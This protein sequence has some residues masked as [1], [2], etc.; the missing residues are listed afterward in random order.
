MN[1]INN[2]S[3]KPSRLHTIIIGAGPAGLAAANSLSALGINNFLLIERGRA[4]ENRQRAREEDIASGVGGAGLY[5]DGKFSF[6]PSATWLWKNLADDYL[7]KS[8]EWLTNTLKPYN[9]NPPDF[10]GQA[11]EP[12]SSD[13]TFKAYPS[14]YIDFDSRYQLIEEWSKQFNDN[15]F[16]ETSYLDIAKE[17]NE[18]CVTTSKGMFFSQN[19]VIATGRMG[20]LQ[21]PALTLNVDQAFQRI[22]VGVR[23]KGAYTHSFFQE[24]QQHGKYLDPKFIF[25]HPEH[26]NVSWRAFCFCKRGEI[27]NSG[28]DGY[29]TLSGR[30]DCA[31]TDESNIGFN[32]RIKLPHVSHLLPKLTEPFALN[33]GDVYSSP[34]TLSNYYAPEIAFYVAEG[35]IQLRNH[36]KSLN[37]A[38]SLEIVGPTIEGVGN[39][40][41]VRK[42][43]NTDYPG[44]YAVGDAVGL[45]RGLTAALL[46]GHYIGQKIVADSKSPSYHQIAEKVI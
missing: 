15:I 2:I 21:I 7:I 26:P 27:M 17:E 35:F 25:N 18:Y 30:A 43:L 23:I 37:Q 16:Y 38:D 42:K 3:V 9:V 13:A 45:F 19:V 41:V 8:Y 5:S 6:Y 10:N 22:E 34:E 14:F 32:T 4:L 28:S 24:L 11:T 20:P 12:K 46:S 31:P 40:P 36:F 39:Y 1:P 29:I 33:L 44:F